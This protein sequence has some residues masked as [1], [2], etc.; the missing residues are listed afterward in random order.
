MNLLKELLR[1]MDTTD[2]A[3]ACRVIDSIRAEDEAAAR[4]YLHAMTGRGK[5]LFDLA[6]R[7]NH[8]ENHEEDANGSNQN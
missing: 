8:F 4:V 1:Q 6:L 5:A 7:W 3:L 2:R